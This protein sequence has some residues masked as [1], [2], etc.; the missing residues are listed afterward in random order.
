MV[1]A[2]CGALSQWSFFSEFQL[3]AHG[4]PVPPR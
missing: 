2:A 3:T 1:G 4:V